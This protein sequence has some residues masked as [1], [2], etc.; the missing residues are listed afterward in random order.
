MHTII[1]LATYKQL[2][3]TFPNL[4]ECFFF[5]VLETKRN[6]A[7]LFRQILIF[8]LVVKREKG[9]M[10]SILR[11][12]V[13]GPRSRHPEAGLDLCYV[14]DQIIAT[15][16]PSGTYPQRAY[17]NPLHQLVKFLDYKHGEEWAIWEFRAEGT[18]YP[19]SEVYGRVWHYPWPDHHP[20]PFRLVPMIMG[21]M[22]NWLHEEKTKQEKEGK[23]RVVVVHCKAGKGRSGTMACSY[24]ISEC[25]WDPKEALARFTER[26]MRPGFGQ[27]VSIPSQLRWV[28][29]VERWTKSNKIYVERQ[30]EI[31]EVHVW[32]LRDG[33]KVQVEGFV[34]EG[35]TIKLFHVFTKKERVIVEGNA[36]GGGGVKDMISDIAGL[37][38]EKQLGKSKTSSQLGIDDIK[39]PTATQTLP[40]QVDDTNNSAMPTPWKSNDKPNPPEKKQSTTSVDSTGSES[41]GSAVIFK[42]S[43]RVILPTS[44][45]NIDFERRNKASMGWT[46][47]TAVAHVWFNTYF[48]GRG[49]EQNGKPDE[50]GVFEIE[51]DK[52]DGIKGSSRK[53]TR[54]FEK[55]A[56]VWKA[57]N[58]PGQKPKEEEIHEPGLD[59]PVP[60]M[61]PADWKG[62]NETSP[63]VGKDLGLR[64]ESPASAAVSK[65]SSEKSNQNGDSDSEEGV[66]TCGPDGKEVDVNVDELPSKKEAGGSTSSKPKGSVEGVERGFDTASSTTP[67]RKT[68]AGHEGDHNPTKSATDISEFIGG[69]PT[70]STGDLPGGVPPEEMKSPRQHGLGHLQ[71]ANKLI[72]SS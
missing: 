35:K 46:M 16:G 53:G 42:P 24:L 27:G 26:R 25:G 32:G 60:Q 14:T 51:W 47:V 43:T 40:A 50:S 4:L 31:M 17:R 28:G 6:L 69:S 39:K 70:V 11:Q 22:R 29:Y 67:Q 20:P 15:S 3:T 1:N 18:G 58:P 48:E 59:S 23:K 66:K 55:L 34:D 30:I 57:Y 5:L 61:A 45:I 38:S 7:G 49:P 41:G 64:T 68:M 56:V 37:A 63:D 54:A 12:I 13:A 8:L 62:G 9:D 72:N 21:S 44:D 2:P 33:V 71:A 52:M 36:P 65:A 10:A 19:D